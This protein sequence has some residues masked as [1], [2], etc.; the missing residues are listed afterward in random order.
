[1]HVPIF[2]QEQLDYVLQEDPLP[3]HYHDLV[4]LRMMGAFQQVDSKSFGSY[5]FMINTTE[6]PCPESQLEIF[7]NFFN[8]KYIKASFRL[9]RF[10]EWLHWKVGYLYLSRL[11]NHLAS[12]LHWLFEYVD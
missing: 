1:M 11:T 3:N 8:K 2:V 4:E 10:H 7:I 6:V 12:W 5:D 9:M